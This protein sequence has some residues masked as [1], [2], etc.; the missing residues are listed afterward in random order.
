[1]KLLIKII[2]INRKTQKI[3]KSFQIIIKLLIKNNNLNK[4]N[5]RIYK[6]KRINNKHK[7]IIY[8]KFKIKS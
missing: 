5:N 3:L 7:I 1:M 4:K 2:K 6:N 8:K